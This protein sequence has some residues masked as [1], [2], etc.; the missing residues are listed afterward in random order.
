MAAR[1]RQA[2]L[3]HIIDPFEIISL[4]YIVNYL[5]IITHQML[6]DHIRENIISWLMR[7][8]LFQKSY[9]CPN[10]H[11]LCRYT[12]SSHFNDKKKLKC[13]DCTVKE[14]IRVKSFFESSHLTLYQIIDCLYFWAKQQLLKDILKQIN[15]AIHTAV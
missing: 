12:Q 10:C 4:D 1:G 14:S 3:T 8:G 7:H 15:V 2:A 9:E 5:K 13:N 6:C 11:K